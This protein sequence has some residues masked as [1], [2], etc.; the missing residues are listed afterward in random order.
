LALNIIH[1]A[2]VSAC[3]EMF[4]VMARTAKS[5]IIY[6]VLIFH[7]RRLEGDVTARPSL[8][9]FADARFQRQRCLGQRAGRPRAGR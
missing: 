6:D 5:P 8:P 9:V 3:E 4:A 7:R 2:L 1:N